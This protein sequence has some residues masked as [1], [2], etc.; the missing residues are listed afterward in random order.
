MAERAYT[1][2]SKCWAVLTLARLHGD[3]LAAI[4]AAGLSMLALA[5]FLHPEHLH[6]PSG[7]VAIHAHHYSSPHTVLVASAAVGAEVMQ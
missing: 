7:G 3:T 5:G 2:L 1:M 4:G 6:H